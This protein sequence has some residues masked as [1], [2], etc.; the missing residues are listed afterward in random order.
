[1][2]CNIFIKDGE[3]FNTSSSKNPVL[4]LKANNNLFATKPKAILFLAKDES[5]S[6]LNK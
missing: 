6:N 5:L 1:M 4:F 2:F 3:H